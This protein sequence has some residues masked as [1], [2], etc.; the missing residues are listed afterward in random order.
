[1]VYASSDAQATSLAAFLG[2]GDG[3]SGGGASLI[4][5]GLSILVVGDG[6]DKTVDD[7]EA[8]HSLLVSMVADVQAQ[9]VQ[10]LSPAARGSDGPMWREEYVYYSEPGLLLDAGPSG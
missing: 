6:E 9:L 10:G 7:D 5:R 3:G 4:S 8:D 1:M 2:S